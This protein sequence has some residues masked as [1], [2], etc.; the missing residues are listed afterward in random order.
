MDEKTFEMIRST[1]LGI[2]NGLGFGDEGID[3]PEKA[4][5]I[6]NEKLNELQEYAADNRL[7]AYEGVDFAFSIA[8]E[9]V[10]KEESE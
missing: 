2:L 4:N 6:V 3:L 8:K 1:A 10:V 7:T 5:E 9:F